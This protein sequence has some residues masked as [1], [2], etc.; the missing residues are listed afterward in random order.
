MAMKHGAVRGAQGTQ[1]R[2]TVRNVIITIV[3]VV[4]VVVA[5]G[6]AIGYHWYKKLY[7]QAMQ[8]KALEQDA[9]SLMSKGDAASN[10]DYLAKIEANLPKAQQDTAQ[11]KQIVHGSDWNRAAK[12]PRVG[13]DIVAVQ[14]LADVADSLISDVVPQFGTVV[15]GLKSASLTTADGNLNLQPISDASQQMSAVNTTLQQQIA[16]LDAVKEPVIDK[17]RTQYDA[18]V[19][20]MRS[21][22]E[23]LNGL[24]ALMV[25]LPSFAGASGTRTYAILAQ[26]T[27]EARS[28]GGLV[29]SMGSMTMT[30]GVISVGDF[31]GDVQW[32]R[33]AGS[34]DVTDEQDVL[35]NQKTY[36][37]YHQEGAQ[38]LYGVNVHNMT[39]NPNFPDVAQ[40]ANDFWKAASFGGNGADC[41]G[42]VSLDPYA[43]QQLIAVSGDVTMPDGRV[44]N[45]TNTAQFLLHDVYNEVAVSQ[46]DL[47]FGAVAAQVV[48]NVFSDMNV[49]KLMQLA[50]VLLDA[51]KGNHVYMWSFHTE[52]QQ[53]L[54]DAGLTGELGTDS[55]KPELGVYMQQMNPSKLDWYTSRNATLTKSG[56]GTY[57]VHYTFTNTLT[58]NDGQ[59]SYITGNG[60][61]Q[62]VSVESIYLYPPAGGTISNV[63]L[64]SSETA[65]SIDSTAIDGRTVWTFQA[66]IRLGTSVSVDFDVQC[67]QGSQ[68]LTLRQTPSGNGE[69]NVDYQY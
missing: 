55:T 63:S 44:L 5:T 35:F 42:V 14:T 40:Q 38:L 24:S 37:L 19:S 15:T 17:I 59:A 62:G 64:S 28:T 8:V 58:S 50:D 27:S 60:I 41:D 2:H 3:V 10:E 11:A 7:A 69:F 1:S 57:H 34:A 45:G 61:A 48:K 18:A 20:K 67:A 56:D 13:G 29:G 25:T 4:L 39:A 21:L 43:L 49:S 23:Q 53:S 9:V 22:A 6:G 16:A 68:A 26:T 47:Y 46:Q 12:L 30:N 36:G 51:A 54:R 31:Y 33:G 66:I 32:P 65:D 52:D